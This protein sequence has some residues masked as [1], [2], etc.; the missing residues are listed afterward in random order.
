VKHK[1]L[2]VGEQERPGQA[3]DV[4]VLDA[5]VAARSQ[6]Q[7]LRYVGGL[8]EAGEHDHRYLAEV[9]VTAEPLEDGEAVGVGQQD[10]EQHHVRGRLRLEG[11]DGLPEVGR[12]AGGESLPGEDPIDLDG[13]RPAVCSSTRVAT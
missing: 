11:P 5:P 6:G 8:A 12:H 4:H 2:V 13:M 10:V 3:A 7:P 9:R 1:V